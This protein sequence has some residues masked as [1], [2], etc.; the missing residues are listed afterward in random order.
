MAKYKFVYT[1]TEVVAVIGHDTIIA[2]EN[3]AELI[4]DL[5]EK[6]D[7]ITS[8]KALIDPQKDSKAKILQKANA[9]FNYIESELD[10]IL[11]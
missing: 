4:S 5:Q 6:L 9:L 7:K 8:D 2:D 11:T 10:K 3:G 1:D